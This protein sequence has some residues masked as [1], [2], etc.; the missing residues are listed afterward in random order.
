MLET[1]ALVIKYGPFL[2]LDGV[3]ISVGDGEIV[4]V[5][6]ANGAG[7]SSLVRA[8][9]GLVPAASGRVA[10]K[11]RALGAEPPHQRNRMGIALVPEG[12]GLFARMS[13]EENLMMGGYPLPTRHRMA[14]N[15]QR[16]F[17]LFPVLRERRH[18][19]AGTL[20]GG[21]QQMLAVGMGLMSEPK[22][23]ILDEPS[24]GLAPI[25]IG[26]IGERLKQLKSLGMTILLAE[27]NATLTGNITDRI[28]VLQTGRVRYHDRPDVLFKM[29]EVAE[30]FLSI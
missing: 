27:Q 21:Q 30:S 7:K 29:P 5:I 23:L 3:D 6:G 14:D 10:F 25:V 8:I 11:G 1:E 9:A 18:Q 12:R 20:S 28:Y 17:D 22:L 19:L 16:C 2:A 24:L 15:M 26:E 13:V 4:G